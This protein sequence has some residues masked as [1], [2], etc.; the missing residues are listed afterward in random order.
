MPD[1]GSPVRDAAP[2]PRPVEPGERIPE[3]DVLRGFALFG[4][5][6]AY[7]LWNLGGPP[8]ETY[9]PADRALNW[10]LTVLVD[11]KFYA[12]FAFLFGLGFSIQ[13]TRARARGVSVVPA[14]CR[15]LLALLLIGL[16]H[17]LLLRNG[18]ILVPYAATGF[19]LLLFR[20]APN[21]AL[22]AG[23]VAGL[24]FPY[25]ARGAWELSG[26]PFPER[27]QTEGMGH[28]AGNYA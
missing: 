24:L 22:A 27:P 15:R 4:V 5:L 3:L 28:L 14:Y 7:A 1:N 16:A 8:E 21:G 23:A 20:N 13:L 10:A 11:T 19:S 9:G 2:T 17:A 26:V 18:D 6:V 12:L 25:L